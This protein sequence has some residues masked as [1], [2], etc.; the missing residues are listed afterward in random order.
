MELLVEMAA[1]TI[2]A[3]LITYNAATTACEKGRQ[4]ELALRLLTDMNSAMIEM[5]GIAY[6]AA[7]GA[8]EKASQSPGSQFPRVS[9]PGCSLSLPRYTGR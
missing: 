6:S 2:E 3:Q 9:I 7:I 4:W 1:A 8:W 5:G